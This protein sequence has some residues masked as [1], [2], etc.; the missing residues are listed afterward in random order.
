[1]Q[2]QEAHVIMVPGALHMMALGALLIVVLVA[3]AT[4]GLAGK[5]IVAPAV[6]LIPV[7][8]ALV[9]MVLGVPHMMVLEVPHIVVQVGDAMLAQVVRVI[10]VL[11]A[12]EKNVRLFANDFIA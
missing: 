8:E 2:V 1:M 10:Q 4:R 11:V 7:P 9:T 6:R 5:N 12:M 3:H